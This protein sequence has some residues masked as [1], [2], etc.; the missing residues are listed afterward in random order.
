MD[1]LVVGDGPALYLQNAPVGVEVG[2][3]AVLCSSMCVW[4][5]ESVLLQ[6]R[7]GVLELRPKWDEHHSKPHTVGG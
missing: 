2:A 4:D 3:A 5:D 6:D 1:S 7:G